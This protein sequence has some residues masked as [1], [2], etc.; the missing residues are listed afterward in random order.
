M[1]KS[2][3]TYFRIGDCDRIGAIE[4]QDDDAPRLRN[5]GEQSICLALD[6]SL[7]S[8][9][10][11]MPKSIAPHCFSRHPLRPVFIVLVLLS[12]IA[13]VPGATQTAADA[14]ELDGALVFWRT[15]KITTPV[16]GRIESLPHR[17]GATVKKGDVIATIDTKQFEADLAIA[18]QGLARAHA[19]LAKAEARLKSEQSAYDRLAKLKGSSAISRGSLEDAENKLDEAKADV[20]VA[21]AEIAESKASVDRR[22]LDIKLATVT[23]PFD[24]IIAQQLITVGGLVSTEDPQILVLVDNTMP[25]IEAKVPVEQ[26]RSLNV[27]TELTVSIGDNVRKTARVR[28]IMPAETSGATSRMVRLELLNLEGAYSDVLPVKIYLPE[29]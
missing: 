12:A 6:Y 26:V 28:A 21:R 13:G 5:Y 8:W 25:E 2:N 18:Q 15:S 4:A 23:A 14:A 10:L 27:G 16:M 11:A 20:D 24:G 3:F 17:V 7:Y 1:G 9:S 29:S 22:E 19:E